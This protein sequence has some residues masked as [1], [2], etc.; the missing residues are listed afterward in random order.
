MA[1]AYLNEGAT[2]FVAANWSDATGFANAATLV[3]NRPAGSG[4]I[5]AGLDQ[6]ALTG[7]NYVD[8]I[9]DF[10]GNVGGTG[11]SLIVDADAADTD[12]TTAGTTGANVPI[13]RVRWWPRAGNIWYTAGS[14]ATTDVCNNF[15]I[16]NGTGYLTGGDFKRI[17]SE[18]AG[19]VQFSAAA[20]A[21]AS[22]RWFL[23]GQGSFIDTHASDALV[24]TV[25]YEGTHTIK[26]AMGTIYVGGTATLIVDAGALN[27]TSIYHLGGTVRLINFGAIGNYYGWGGLLDLS[28]LA[29]AAAFTACELCPQLTIKP[30]N[31]LDYGTKTIIGSGPKSM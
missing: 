26:R 21:N 30:S 18:G 28:G 8:F 29:R 10:S 6:S 5:Q 12:T 9:G 19:F 7:I 15:Q 1:I 13:S 31:L 2:S 22:A 25:L 17:H 27:G 4:G 24:T 23:G 16:N 11:G 3:A 20:T 14:D